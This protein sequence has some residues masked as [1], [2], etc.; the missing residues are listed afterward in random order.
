MA[1]KS[2]LMILECFFAINEQNLNIIVKPISNKRNKLTVLSIV[3]Q[4]AEQIQA[5]ASLRRILHNLLSK[6]F[7]G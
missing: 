6:L 2:T 7:K 1:Q 5:F 4:C 3:I